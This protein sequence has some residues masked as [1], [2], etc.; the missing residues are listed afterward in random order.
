[1]VW[2]ERRFVSLLALSL[3]LCTLFLG[4][5]T[6]SYGLLP[7]LLSFFT[8]ANGFVV[9]STGASNTFRFDRLSREPRLTKAT[10]GTEPATGVKLTPTGG[11]VMPQFPVLMR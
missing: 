7:L 4:F 2:T 3:S 1:M 11:S 10:G 9:P 5:F 6:L 8:L